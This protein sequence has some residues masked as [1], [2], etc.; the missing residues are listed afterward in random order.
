MGYR[1]ATKRRNLAA[2]K[3]MVPDPH[4]VHARSPVEIF[5]LGDEAPF[6]Q[7]GKN[8]AGRDRVEKFWMALRNRERIS[9][10]TKE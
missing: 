2:R 9:K 8:R 5:S 3:L 1:P 4:D 6:S 10:V 7:L